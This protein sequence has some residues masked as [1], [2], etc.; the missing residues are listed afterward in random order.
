MRDSYAGASET[1]KGHSLLGEGYSGHI[2]GRKQSARCHCRRSLDIV[3]ERAELV[4]ITF[5]ESSGIYTGE[6]FPLE[7]QVL[8]AMFNHGNESVDEFL[9]LRTPD[10]IV[11]PT[12]IKRVLQSFFVFGSNIEKNRQATFR[13]YTRERG[14]ERHL[15]DWNAHATG[16]LVAEAKNS[17]AIAYDDAFDPLITRV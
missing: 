4:P 17:L 11:T 16:A 12:D 1:E 14:I 15:A 10:A 8:P 5:Q 6:I 7:Q 3:I 9:V 13:R 2:N